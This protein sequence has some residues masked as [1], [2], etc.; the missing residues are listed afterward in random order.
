MLLLAV[1]L[2][3]AAILVSAIGV[4][5]PA[6][7]TAELSDEPVT[8]TAP[9]VETRPPITAND[10]FPEERDVTS[11][12]GVLERPG[13]GS[14]SRGGWR[15]TLILVAIFGG[16]AVVFA[17]VVRGVRKNRREQQSLLP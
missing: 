8:T 12:I 17:N 11:C 3:S 6:S 16:L 9:P 14:E 7:A 13:C 4:H 15:Q 10:F 5:G 1:L 2:A